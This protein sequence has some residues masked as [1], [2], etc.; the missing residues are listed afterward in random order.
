MP[1]RLR[2]L[3]SAASPTRRSRILRRSGTSASSRTSTTVSRRWQIAC[4]SSPVWSKSGRCVRSTWTAWTSSVNAA[5]PSRLRT[6]VC[7]D[8]RR[9]R[10]RPPPHRHSRPRRLHVRGLPCA[11]SMR[12]RNSAG[13]CCSG[14]RAQTLANLYLAMEKDLKIIPVLNKIDLPAADPDRYAEEIA[15]ITGCER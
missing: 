14:H 2:G 6:F 3:P 12:G 7:L 11:R 5:S 15:H 8:R 10:V 1:V 9:R 13:R 4:F